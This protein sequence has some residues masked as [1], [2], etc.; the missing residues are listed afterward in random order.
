MSGTADGSERLDDL[1]ERPGGVELVRA[2]LA[3]PR[4]EGRQVGQDPLA[5]GP[6]LA[7]VVGRAA[8][9]ALEQHL[10]RRAEQH[11]RLEAVVEPAL[12][13]DAARDVERL[14]ARGGEQ[15]RD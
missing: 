2:G 4:L 5:S 6:G 15:L 14:A 11:D 7:E 13:R 12:V 10:G 8:A 3:K 1:R 9:D